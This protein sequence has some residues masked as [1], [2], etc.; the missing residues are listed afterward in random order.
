MGMACKIIDVYFPLTPIPVI[1]VKAKIF[2]FVI[3]KIKIFKMYLTSVSDPYSLNPVPG[4]DPSFFYTICKFV[5]IT[6][7]L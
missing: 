2:V 6:S 3:M 4:P 1:A 7:E 5:L